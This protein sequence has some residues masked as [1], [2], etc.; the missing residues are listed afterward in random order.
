MSN[1]FSMYLANFAVVKKNI[2]CDAEKNGIFL[3][4]PGTKYVR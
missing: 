2:I 4:I 1:F 3:F